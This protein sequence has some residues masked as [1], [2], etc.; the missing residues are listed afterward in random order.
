MN[1]RIYDAV[2][3]RFLSADP[4]VD[5]ISDAQG[6]NRYSYVGNNPMGATDPTGFF[7]LKDGLKIVA[8]V[9]LSIV[10]YGAASVWATAFLYA[11]TTMF[12]STAITLGSVIGGAAAGFVSGFAGSL[13]SGGNLGDA[14]K[15]GVIGGVVGALTAGIGAKF[16]HS[17]GSWENE[18]ERGVAHGAVGGALEKVQGGQFRHGFYSSFIGSVAGSATMSGPL[19]GDDWD[20]IAERTAISAVAG[21]TASALGGG[22]FANGAE[23]AGFQHLFND[24]ASFLNSMRT[25]F[26]HTFSYIV[27]GEMSPSGQ[28]TADTGSKNDQLMD[29]AVA[30]L[31]LAPAAIAELSPIRSVFIL[32]GGGVT[33][34]FSGYGLFGIS[35]D[36]GYFVEGMGEGQYGHFAA[37]SSGALSGEAANYLFAD[38]HTQEGVG[39]G[40]F[41][42]FRGW[43]PTGEAGG[44][45]YVAMFGVDVGA[46]ASVDVKRLYNLF[47]GTY[48][49]NAHYME[50]YGF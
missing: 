24:E 22:K 3:G 14:F 6:Y 36:S 12:M 10:T 2:L 1:G 7:S 34:R 40:A 11:N 27:G 38:T 8:V 33:D 35:A 21:G 47:K 20:R 19:S 28:V 30:K 50:L 49:G 46:G 16:G 48:S 26:R 4:N 13:L 15:S 32:A 18:F 9:V 45:G 25:M 37:G 23:T 42:T 31:T 17:P 41:G 39:G 43:H 44:Y 29:R 5:G